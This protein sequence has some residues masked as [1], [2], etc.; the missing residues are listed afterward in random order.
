MQ[1]DRHR[2]IITGAPLLLEGTKTPRH[3]TLLISVMPSCLRAFELAEARFRRYRHRFFAHRLFAGVL[4]PVSGPPNRWTASARAASTITSSANTARIELTARKPQTTGLTASP[5]SDAVVSRPNPVPRTLARNDAG[6]GRVGGGRRRPRSTTRRTASRETTSATSFAASIAAAST[7]PP[8]RPTPA[9]SCAAVRRC[10]SRRRSGGRSR[11]RRR[12]S[13]TAALTPAECAPRWCRARPTY[14]GST[15]PKL[16]STNC[17]PKITS[18]INR[19]FSNASTSRNVTDRRAAPSA[20]AP[21]RR[22]SPCP[23]R[24]R[25]GTRRR[26]R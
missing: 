1:H 19:K 13:R 24:R 26:A 18:A 25:S 12:R 22:A 14:S 9:I 15:G 20:P 8:P 4:A 16:R 10:S 17:R 2:A 23:S 3:K 5:I 6:S 11:R 21:C 7:A